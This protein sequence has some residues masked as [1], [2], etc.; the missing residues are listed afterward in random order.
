M[1]L[2]IGSRVVQASLHAIGDC[3]EAWAIVEVLCSSSS[4]EAEFIAG[5]KKGAAHAQ[6]FGP[7]YEV[8]IYRAVIAAHKAYNPTIKTVH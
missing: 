2:S 1:A 4:D 6:F 7:K 8:A 3:H 5:L